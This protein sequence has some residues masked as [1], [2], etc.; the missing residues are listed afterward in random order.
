[1]E[2][3][4]GGT[5]YVFVLLKERRLSCMSVKGVPRLRHRVIDT[6]NDEILAATCVR[7]VMS[8]FGQELERLTEREL[9]QI[10]LLYPLVAWKGRIEVASWPQYEQPGLRLAE[11]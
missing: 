2:E 9:H 6:L 10:G 11:V 3:A 8:H 7:L 4:P 5:V 1:M